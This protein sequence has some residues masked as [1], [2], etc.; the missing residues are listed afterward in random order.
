LLGLCGPYHSRSVSRL[1]PR[2]LATSVNVRD[3]SAK[4]AATP[5]ALNSGE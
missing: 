1:T 2:S 4:Y 3:G 5:L